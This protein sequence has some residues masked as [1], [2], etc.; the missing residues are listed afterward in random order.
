MKYEDSTAQALYT[1]YESDFRSPYEDRARVLA[2][3]TIPYLFPDENTSGQDEFQDT[4]V[5]SFGARA[6]N[7]LSGKLLM[8][9]IPANRSFFRFSPE[10][11][12][13]QNELTGKNKKAEAQ[14]E[15]MFGAQE[16]KIMK[17][18]EKDGVRTTAWEM[19][20]HG[21][22]VGNYLLIRDRK[23]K[24]WLEFKLDEF[25]V[26]RD[27]VDT[28]LH[29]ITKEKIG[30]I[31]ART[32]GIEMEESEED[33]DIYSHYF[34]NEDGTKYEYYQEAKEEIIAGTEATFSVGDEPF[35]HVRWTRMKG[36]SYGR[37]FCEQFV[38]DLNAYNTHSRNLNIGTTIASKVVPLVNPN[39]VTDIDDLLDSEN[40]E[41]IAGREEDIGVYQTKKNYD[42]QV[43]EK[44]LADL[45][46]E[47]SY[48]FLMTS[49]A[50]R[51]AERV[52][53]EEIKMMAQELESALGGIYSIMS[54]EVQSK[55]VYEYM[56]QEKMDFGGAV[57][58]IVTT[59]ISALGRNLELEA[60]NIF[61]NQAGLLANIVGAEKVAMKI[62][63]DLILNTMA[64]G[65]GLNPNDVI[66]S[67]ETAGANKTTETQ[68]AL[69]VE[70][71]QAEIARPPAEGTPQ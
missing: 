44:R 19:I 57:E 3:L 67:D 63:T 39:G 33:V 36:E 60:T 62:N 14:L 21:M 37:P 10:D 28:V 9:I 6:V 13:E 69:E 7:N 53:R 45:K 61:L 58:P 54:K 17:Q 47:L 32:L 46:Q 27:A 26:H 50:V 71:A 40:G 48:S 38:G 11:E 49:G 22:V 56:K 16:R 5:Q 2:K 29:I 65:V 59:G 51:D 4:A 42:F 31:K 34:L 64:N 12:E 68:Q 18:V 25:V 52:T 43:T 1:K 23:M 55:F 8:T 15:N 35:M 41:P 66:I 30:K 24:R 70:K 20:R